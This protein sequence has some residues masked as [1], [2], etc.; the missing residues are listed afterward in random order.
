MKFLLPVHCVLTEKLYMLLPSVKLANPI[1]LI[2]F[3]LL[4]SSDKGTV[5]IFALKDTRFN[6]RSAFERIG[7]K[8]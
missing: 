3:L 6:K 8:G 4:I 2:S 7:M 1:I 5:H